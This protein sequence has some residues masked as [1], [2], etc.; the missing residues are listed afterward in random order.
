MQDITTIDWH[1]KAKALRFRTGAFIDG[2]FVEAR[3]GRSFQS[4]SPV[5]GRVLTD[6][7]C[8]GAEDVDIAV[9]AARRA[10]EDGRWRGQAPADRKAVLCRLADLIRAHRDEL[11]LLET[12]D[13]GKP[14]ADS[15][16]IDV[17]AT[18]NCFDWYG[19]A[20][21]KIY[22]EIAPT[23]P[24]TVAM[25][26]RE[27]LGVVAAVV[28]WNFPMVMAA[29]KVAPALATGNSVVLKPSEM[30]SLSALRLAELAAEAGVP[31]GVF[32]VITGWGPETGRALGLH[33]DV[34]GLFFTGSTQVGKHFME[35]S[36]QSNLKRLGLELGGKSPNL[37]LGSYRNIRH[38][39]E[40]SAGSAF[41]NQGEMCTCPSRLIVE[42]SVHDEVVEILRERAT[43]FVPGN[44]L[45]PL[46]TMGALVSEN[47]A[48]RVLDFVDVARQDGATLALGGNRVHAESGGSYVQPTIFTDV[49][50][51]MRIAREEVFGPLL[52]VIRVRDVDEAIK[53]ANDSCFGLASAVW[54]DDL[55]TA[56]KVSGAIRAGLVYVNCYDCDDMTTPF[57]GFKESG[58][59]RDK[60]LHALDKYT[61]MKTTWMNVSGA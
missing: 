16:S 33:M 20:I 21:D 6:I 12:L 15:T 44:P 17:R 3:S 61:E 46:T 34:D 14:I 54:T 26:T 48:E 55:A 56:H 42:D 4:V 30:S 51:H 24:G 36:A 19:E 22:D 59:G 8:C 9:A 43:T 38:A 18:A 47:H 49:G 27:P 40:V 23:A 1:Q 13:M 53:V 28:P 31:P 29:W 57:G 11:A 25:V 52:S 50:N 35:Y 5:D 45:D 37:I 10:F 32:N 60:S 7:A 58:I 2:D 39:A 41:F